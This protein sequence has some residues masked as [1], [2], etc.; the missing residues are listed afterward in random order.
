MKSHWL[1]EPSAAAL[2]LRQS[3]IRSLWI[4]VW[5]AF[6]GV[7]LGLCSLLLAYGN[8]AQAVFLSYFRHPVLLA[9]NLLPALLLT[10]LLTALTGRA[11]VGFFLSG[12]VVL[13]LS[14]GNYV[15]LLTRDDPLL[16]VDLTLLR[17][18]KAIADTGDYQLRPNLRLAAV[19]L[20]FLLGIVILTLLC[21]GSIPGRHRAAAGLLALVL[22]AADLY[23]SF[24]TNRYN[25]LKN[26][27]AVEQWSSTQVYLSKGFLYPFLHSVS[28]SIVR[29]PEGYRG[30]KW[31]AEQLAADAAAQ[32]PDDKKVDL[33]TIQLEAFA[34]FS[35]FENVE[36]VAF[37]RAYDTWHTLEREGLSGN[38]ITNIFAGGTVDTER[39]CLTGFA[40]YHDFRRVT[41]SAAWYLAAQGY[42]LSGSHPSND[43]F[44]N[45]KN[46][47]QYLGFPDYYYIENHYAP[48]T[49]GTFGSDDV[50]LPEILRLYQEDCAA[51]DAPIF[52]FNVTYQGHGPYDT[53]NVWRGEHYTDG[54]YSET[55][56]NIL[57]NYL[58]SVR[59][60]SENLWTFT[61]A[62]EKQS[63]PVVL[64]LFG[65]HKPWLGVGNSGYHELGVDLD[66][67]SAEGIYNYYSTRYLIW[68]NSA[69]KEALGVTLSGEGP[70]VSSCFMLQEVFDVL[71]LPET[72]YMRA[73]SNA[74]AVLP[75]ITS[76][77]VCQDAAGNFV[78]EDALT[79]EQQQALTDFHSLEYYV[80]SG[81]RYS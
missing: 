10:L 7:G 31:A 72:P 55:T 76:V 52:S 20:A 59:N 27:D 37:G 29:P 71:G 44:Y 25:S 4:F 42:H 57:D 50:L 45:R 15:K 54:R 36:G 60:T 80:F 12:F 51:S 5:A 14:L 9:L 61:R 63:R 78:S 17:E 35:R 1:F 47:N 69:A 64:L 49:G 58:G 39:C 56:A 16:F 11:N 70:D 24:D 67:S 48:L 66:P 43:W 21:R 33:I 40:S 34:D 26:L 22:L 46:V 3:R 6:G 2:P 32:I 68:A 41:D 73:A 81:G 65:D 74:R 19:L 23:V 28:S 62:L 77:G 18:A 30:D 75:V 13:G 79:N 38:L 8:Y 53:T